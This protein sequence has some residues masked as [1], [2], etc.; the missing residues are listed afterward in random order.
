MILLIQIVAGIVFIYFVVFLKKKIKENTKFYT[1]EYSKNNVKNNT[2][3]YI[4]KNTNKYIENNN[5]KN[6]IFNIF[7]DTKEDIVK[8]KNFNTTREEINQLF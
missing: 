5:K 6:N 4:K 7:R 2:N 3:Y 1:Y 8:Y